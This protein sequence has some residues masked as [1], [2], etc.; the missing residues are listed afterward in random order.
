METVIFTL[1]IIW[2]GLHSYNHYKKEKILMKTINELE[3]RIYSSI[4]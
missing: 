2:M 4:E 1:I 3:E